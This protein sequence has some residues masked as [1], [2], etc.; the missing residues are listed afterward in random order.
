MM[1][2]PLDAGNGKAPS[3]QY[4]TKISKN[5]ASSATT[6]TQPRKRSVSAVC[7]SWVASNNTKPLSEASTK[8]QRR[9][10]PAIRIID[11]IATGREGNG[12]L[13][14]RLQHSPDAGADQ[15]V[16][17]NHEAGTTICQRFACAEEDATANVGS[18]GDDLEIQGSD[19]F[20]CDMA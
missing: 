13:S 18:K 10:D 17:N 20:P 15:E 11:V 5:I 1:F 9:V 3:A 12:H 16:S 6:A 19:Q 2:D 14:E 7:V 8:S 4:C